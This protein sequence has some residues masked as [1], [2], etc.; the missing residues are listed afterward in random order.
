M[1]TSA[2]RQTSVR[3]TPTIGSMSEHDISRR[4]ME[5]IVGRLVLTATDRG[6]THIDRIEDADP[7][8]QALD[9]SR[10]GRAHL[11]VAERA[12]ER[13]FAGASRDLAKIVLAP[14]GTAFQH[15]VWNALRAIPF[16]TTVSYMQLAERIGRARAVRAVG[17]ANGRNPLPI[18]VPCHRVIGADRSLTGFGLGLP[19]KAWL[20][21][22]E[23]AAEPFRAPLTTATRVE[24]VVSRARVQ[25]PVEYRT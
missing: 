19:V 8:V 21:V 13:Y 9:G 2:N 24:P 20:L 18:V 4:T 22:H 3:V 5:T 10:E 11:D 1:S 25:K 16:G 17:L 15:L 12:L 23:G 7:A 14:R 6:L